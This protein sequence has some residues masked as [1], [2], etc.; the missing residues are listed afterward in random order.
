M[1]QLRLQ[2]MCKRGLKKVCVTSLDVF[3]KHVFHCLEGLSTNGTPKTSP[4]QDRRAPKARHLLATQMAA[5]S[6]GRKR[7]EHVRLRR[8][9]VRFS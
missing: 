8:R 1:R 5:P 3:V 9:K 6:D 2:R 7:R 4:D